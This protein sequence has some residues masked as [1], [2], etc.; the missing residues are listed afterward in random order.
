MIEPAA[1][2]EKLPG[3]KVICRL[4]PAEC[5]LTA[6]KKGI[7]RSRFNRNGELVT[8]NYGEL[9]SL[10][11]D[12]IEKKPLYHFYPATGILSTGPNSCNLGCVNCQNW[13]I[14]QKE[15]QTTF[16][17]PKQL[18]D[19]AVKYK[20]LGVAFTYTEPIVWYEYIIDTAPLLRRAGLKT[21]LVSNGYI[22]PQPLEDLLGHMDAINIDLKSIREEFYKKICKAK[23][24]PVLH[25]IK[26][27][28]ESTVHLEVTNLI[29]PGLNDSDKDLGDLVS[30]VASVSDMIPLHFSAYR[31]DYKLDIPA[32]PMSTML[33][34]REIARRRLKYVYLGNVLLE[35]GSDTLCPN[36]ATLPIRRS[37][38]HTSMVGLNDGCCPNCGF[39]TGIVH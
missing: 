24:E 31:P 9:V 33:R 21:V 15:T 29:I 8:D 38:Y 32:T 25:T 11:V 23:L 35:G 30:F 10:A 27:V 1:Y 28:A 4:C 17:S 36:C 18:A 37:G 6:G 19:T 13:T 14:C 12:P 26:R 7:C 2:S 16:F 5:K 34:A 20:S 39:Q 22:S 3:D